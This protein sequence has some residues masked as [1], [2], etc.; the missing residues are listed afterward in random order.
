MLEL[1]TVAFI[2]ITVYLGV[3]YI[4]S[5]VMNLTA[6]PFLVVALGA[7]LISYSIARI[8]VPNWKRVLDQERREG[9]A[10]EDIIGVIVVAVAG[11]LGHNVLAVRRWGWQRMSIIFAVNILTSF[12]F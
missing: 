9:V 11:I 4:G 8:A 1:T 12:F 5:E 7:A 2:F 6:W 10:K 3:F